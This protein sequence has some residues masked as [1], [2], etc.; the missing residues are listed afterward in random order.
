MVENLE[1]GP[2]LLRPRPESGLGLLLSISG[3]GMA[4]LR[5]HSLP[6]SRSPIDVSVTDVSM[7]VR[8]RA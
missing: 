1:S 3:A 8:K 7:A 4:D 2:L 6:H 5:T